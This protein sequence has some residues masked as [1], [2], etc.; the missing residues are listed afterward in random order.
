MARGRLP[1]F[2]I[3]GAQKCGTTSLYYWLREH[4]SCFLPKIKEPHYF[5]RFEPWEKLVVSGSIIRDEIAY[6]KL[7]AEANEGQI[8]GEASPSYLYETGVATRIAEAQPGCRCIIIVRDP[9]ERAYSQ[10][11]M[12][13]VGGTETRSFLEAIESSVGKKPTSWSEQNDIYIELSR[14]GTQLQ[15]YFDAFPR[16]QILVVTAHTLAADPLEVMK[17]VSDLLQ[18]EAA[19]W[20][21]FDF[22]RHHEGRIPRNPLVKKLLTSTTARAMGRALIPKGARPFVAERVLSKKPPRAE[23]DLQAREIIWSE[24]E[25]EIRELERLLGRRLPELWGSHPDN[26]G[27]STSL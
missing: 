12:N 11:R 6:K 23:F 10:Y 8:C 5:S 9:V 22:K 2:L 24:I 16:D 13:V 7:F 27:K 1:D 18:I 17:Q 14:Y 21:S 25:S 4:P 20:D 3:V 15:R 26:I 19:W